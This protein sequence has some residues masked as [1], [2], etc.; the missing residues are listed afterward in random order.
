MPRRLLILVIF[1]GALVV[2]YLLSRQFVSLESLVVQES[3]L[4]DALTRHPWVGLAAGLVVYFGISLVPGL[5]G[6]ALIV[7]WL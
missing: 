7:G 4:R 1:V 5:T 2:I 3:R 6:K